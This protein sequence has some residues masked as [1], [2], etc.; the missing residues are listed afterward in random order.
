MITI[1]KKC[2]LAAS[3]VL[4]VSVFVPQSGIAQ[5]G[6]A[7][8]ETAQAE[9]EQRYGP[10]QQTDTLWRIA[11]RN[12][13]DDS[14]TVHQVMAAIVDTNP[15]AFRNNSI[16]YMLTGF[17]LDIP[18]LEII[19]AYNPEQ[20]R[21]S[22]IEQLEQPA[23]VQR[24]A[25]EAVSASPSD[26]D[27]AESE[28]VDRQA[29]AAA[30]QAPTQQ[31][32]APV[33]AD[34]ESRLEELKERVEESANRTESLAADNTEIHQRLANVTDVL[35]ELRESVQSN[36][37]IEREVV[38]IQRQQRE[39]QR[40][41]ERVTTQTKWSTPPWVAVPLAI[42]ALIF[43]L[44]IV[45]II[46]RCRPQ[47]SE[48]PSPYQ[49]ATAAHIAGSDDDTESEQEPAQESDDEQSDVKVTA[50]K[51]GDNPADNS[52]TSAA[53]DSEEQGEEFFRDIDEILAE[54]DAA[55]DDEDDDADPVDTEQS[56]KEQLAA[57][58]DLARAYLEMDEKEEARDIINKVLEKADDELKAEAETLLKRIDAS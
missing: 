53:N 45:W 30:T 51:P 56:E 1:I 22:M 37:D 55:A 34:L 5:E 17:Y 58:L 26:A 29:E 20:A 14:V 40:E 2:V 35:D 33:A 50:E 46:R 24:A 27:P 19:Q 54:A 42:L 8:E 28:P 13:P 21:E 16:H 47:K 44:L 32:Q 39:L 57:E 43:L 36:V 11:S 4:A 49:A 18:S 23:A 38:Q 3:L 15:E 52:A 9:Q 7:P 31:V 10:I 48:G 25:S 6:M 12:R 41:Q